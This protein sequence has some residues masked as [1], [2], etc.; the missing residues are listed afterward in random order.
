MA[1]GGQLSDSSSRNESLSSYSILSSKS[2]ASKVY[3]FP[4][5]LENMSEQSKNPRLN[6][7]SVEEILLDF[8]QILFR[9]ILRRIN[10]RRYNNPIRIL[11]Y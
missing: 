3:F 11:L 7:E 9:R 5:A 10:I 4:D 6:I 1:W 2:A 8:L